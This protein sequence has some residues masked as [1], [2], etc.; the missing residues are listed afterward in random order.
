MTAVL[1]DEEKIEDRWHYYEELYSEDCE[2]IDR[3]KWEKGDD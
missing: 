2:R 1:H 3:P